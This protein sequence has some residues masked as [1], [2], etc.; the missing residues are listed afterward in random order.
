[1]TRRHYRT[2]PH[3]SGEA[4]IFLVQCNGEILTYNVHMLDQ[5]DHEIVQMRRR[6]SDT[7]YTVDTSKRLCDMGARPEQTFRVYSQIEFSFHK[8]TTTLRKLEAKMTA[9]HDL[10]IAH[11][12]TV[13]PGKTLGS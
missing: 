10:V 11:S 6:N 2:G 13:H 3:N 5:L 12:Q 8:M 9:V 4:Q 1:M 7:W